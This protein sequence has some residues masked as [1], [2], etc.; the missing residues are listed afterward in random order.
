M[1]SFKIALSLPS[2]IAALALGST[3]AWAA[4]T[5]KPKADAKPAAAK[6]DAKP[7]AVKAEAPKADAAKPDAA[8]EAVKEVRLY[9]L[10]CGHVDFKD[11]GIFADTGE[12]DGKTGTLATP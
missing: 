6:A 11:M 9:A 7:A 10:D 2:L 4:D 8:Q 5:A 1:M 3:L 12:L